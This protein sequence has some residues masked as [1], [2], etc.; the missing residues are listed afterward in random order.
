L[1]PILQKRLYWKWKTFAPERW[2]GDFVDIRFYLVDQLSRLQG[3]KIFDIGCNAGIIASELAANGNDVIGMDIEFESLKPYKKLF[4]QLGLTPKIVNGS[5]DNLMFADNSFDVLL[6]SW[7]FCY[8]ENDEKKSRL[9]SHL[10]RALKPGGSIYFVE[11]NRYCFI[12]GR[13]LEHYWTVDMARAFFETHGFTIEEILGWNPL[14]SILF[15]LP[16]KI[17]S[18]IPHKV[19]MFFYPPGKLVQYVPGW[20]TVFK[21]LG[22]FSITRRYCRSYYLRAKKN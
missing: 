4:N 5:W 13:G 15:W 7:T 6:L 22:K 3:K 19:A 16:W 10:A 2:W 1:F 17:K 20:Y 14:P 18:S 12:Q 21:W 11:A 8:C 9:F